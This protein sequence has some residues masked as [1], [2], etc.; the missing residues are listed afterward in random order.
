MLMVELLIGEG[1]ELRNESLIERESL[2]E[3]CDAVRCIDMFVCILFL[4]IMYLPIYF[5]FFSFMQLYFERDM[6][7]KPALPTL[8]DIIRMNAVAR[9]IQNV[10]VMRQMERRNQA[11]YERTAA[12]NQS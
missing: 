3:L 1:V 7:E 5:S 6:P 11:E 4:S 12:F 8:F 10:Y 9:R 2:M